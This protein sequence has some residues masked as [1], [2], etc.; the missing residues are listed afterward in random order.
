MFKYHLCLSG[1]SSSDSSSLSTPF[2]SLVLAVLGAGPVTLD[3]A[4]ALSLAL[5]VWRG[6]KGVHKMLV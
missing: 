2:P 5:D 3:A 6:L 4:D 1:S